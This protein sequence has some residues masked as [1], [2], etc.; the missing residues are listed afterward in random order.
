L[1]AQRAKLF[2][3]QLA[4]L[5]ALELVSVLGCSLFDK[6]AIEFCVLVHL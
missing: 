3:S 2:V 5:P 6:L 4:F 1:K